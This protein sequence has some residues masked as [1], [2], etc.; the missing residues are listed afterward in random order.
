M[1]GNA[2]SSIS[3]KNKIKEMV[4]KSFDITLII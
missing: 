3:D 4:N 1:Y 2:L